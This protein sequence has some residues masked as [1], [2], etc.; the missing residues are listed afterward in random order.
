[1]S[2]FYCAIQMIWFC[3][4]IYVLGYCLMIEIHIVE[5]FLNDLI[6]FITLIPII[7]LLFPSRL[8]IIFIQFSVYFAI[9]LHI[10]I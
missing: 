2:T 5:V 1:M 8:N 3:L 10:L 7:Y 9:L 6:I 4:E